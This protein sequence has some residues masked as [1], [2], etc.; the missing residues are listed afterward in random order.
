MTTN[1]TVDAASALISNGGAVTLNGAVTA[2]IGFSSSGTTFNNTSGPITTTNSPITINH[3]GTVTLG[4][5]DVGSSTIN[6][7]GSTIN[8]GT[9]T[10]S[11]AVI[12]AATVGLSSQPIL[13]VTNLNS[14]TLSAQD[15]TGTSG[16][17]QKTAALNQPPAE[18]IISVGTVIIAGF[19]IYAAGTFKV[20][21]QAAQSESATVVTQQLIEELLEEA[22]KADFFQEPPL[23]VNIDVENIGLLEE[24]KP[25]EGCVRDP[26]TGE[27][28]P[29]DPGLNIKEQSGTQSK[30]DLFNQPDPGFHSHMPTL[31]FDGNNGSVIPGLTFKALDWEKDLLSLTETTENTEFW[32]N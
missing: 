18:N 6:L 12:S 22:S 4:T 1:S 32:F 14:L 8:A 2:P 16:L 19:P 3:S 11:S 21:L 29:V 23:L 25:E 26:Q 24:F 9:L 17:L 5:I 30:V 20:A 27:C 7:V 10:G 31:L 13:N 15:A 28:V